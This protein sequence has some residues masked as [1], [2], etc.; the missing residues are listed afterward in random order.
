MGLEI[1]KHVILYMS[2]PSGPI[3]LL[4]EMRKLLIVHMPVTPQCGKLV[5]SGG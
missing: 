2:Q 1:R 5:G 4:S 3:T